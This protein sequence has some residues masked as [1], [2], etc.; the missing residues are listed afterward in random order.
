MHKSDPAKITGGGE[1]KEELLLLPRN[2]TCEQ[3]LHGYSVSGQPPVLLC[4][5]SPAGMLGFPRG[6]HVHA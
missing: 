1:V 6:C 2:T 5:F 3:G 4:G